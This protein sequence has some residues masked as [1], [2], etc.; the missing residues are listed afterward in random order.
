MASTISSSMLKQPAFTKSRRGRL[1]DV[2]S[3]R[4]HNR[5]GMTMLPRGEG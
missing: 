2:V 3:L 4:K 1:A 5:P